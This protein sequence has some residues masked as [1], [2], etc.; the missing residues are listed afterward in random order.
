MN[1]DLKSSLVSQMQKWLDDNADDLGA[2][3]SIWQDTQ[4]TGKNAHLMATAAETVLD[5]MA[6]QSALEEKLG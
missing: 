5:A 6:L 2:N 4:P 1:A 3:L